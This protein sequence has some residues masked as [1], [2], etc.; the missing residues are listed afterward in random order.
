MRGNENRGTCGPKLRGINMSPGNIDLEVFCMPCF[1]CFPSVFAF[2]KTFEGRGVKIIGLARIHSD[3]VPTHVKRIIGAKRQIQSIADLFKC[4]T[5]ATRS[6]DPFD[7]AGCQPSAGVQCQAA[8]IFPCKARLFVDLTGRRLDQ[9][10][11]PRVGNA[12]VGG[13]HADGDDQTVWV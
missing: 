4:M 5:C 3:G 11:A 7:V 1:P 9:G 12:P 13:S 2:G 10:Q 6:P 8:H